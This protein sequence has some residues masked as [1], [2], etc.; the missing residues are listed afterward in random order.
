MDHNSMDDRRRA[1]EDEYFRKK[2]RE[3]L[4][5]LRAARAQ[6]GEP[7]RAAAERLCPLGHGALVEMAYDDVFIDR[8]AQCQGVWLDG[9]ELEH[10]M[11]RDEGGGFFKRL[12]GTSDEK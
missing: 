12:F 2:D 11:K 9:G 6:E 3:A 7:E 8:C 5:R 4:E 1:L 10:L